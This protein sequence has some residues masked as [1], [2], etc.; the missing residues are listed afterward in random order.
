MKLR[1]AL[2]C[3]L[4]TLC[5]ISSVLLSGCGSGQTDGGG[6]VYLESGE[7]RPDEKVL[8]F[9]API[10]ANSATAA[11]YQQ[12]I[13]RYNAGQTDVRVI[14]EGI[15]TADG[16]NEFL[17]QRLEAGQGDDIFIVNADS[18]KPLYAKGYFYDL[19]G[20]PTFQKLNDATKGQTMIGD[21]A[22][23]IPLDMTAYALFVNLDLLE[24]YELEPPDD[25]DAFLTCCRT[26]KERGGTPLSLNRWFALT[27]PTMANGLYNLY[28]S[29]QR[30]ELLAKLNSGEAHIGD[31]MLEGFRLFE[32]FV[33]E[34]WYGDGLDS[35]TVNA[36][37][38]DA[39]DIPD[40]AAGKTAFYF[41]ELSAIKRVE[42]ANPE[43][44][45]HVQGVPIP[46]GTVTL[47]AVLSRLSVNANSEHLEESLDFISYITGSSF[48]QISASGNGFLP[49]YDGAAFTLQSER[50]RPAYET[51]LSSGQIPIEDMQ[52]KFTYW[53][54]VRELCIK[55]FD[56]MTPEE[57][58]EE[59]NRIQ[60][61]Q[62]A[63]YD[64]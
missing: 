33:R 27:V 37:K 50:I 55:M 47:P 12:S 54:T 45:Y 43:F 16:F 11:S 30:Q 39:V 44:N 3:L 32:T 6:E 62:I 17:E 60:M 35:A 49:L 18:V 14:F 46:G 15:S 53:D 22:Y 25:L 21:I 10:D 23:C 57:A 29:D 24:Q 19:S 31:S 28:G 13:E 56:G 26:I 51:F 48:Q 20:I 2:S 52:L 8:T 63:G 1:R 41:G 64:S 7:D 61:Q 4:L 38:A 40:F 5:V 36:L 59:Y 42:A 58:A 34:G 9:F